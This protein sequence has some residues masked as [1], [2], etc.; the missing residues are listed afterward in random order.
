LSQQ[1]SQEEQDVVQVEQE[2]LQL[3]A[4]WQHVVG[5]QLSHLLL[6]NRFFIRLNQLS[7]S[8]QLE[9]VEPH[10]PYDPQLLHEPWE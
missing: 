9:Q 6:L 7:F 10:D 5:Q 3:G 8:Q 1:L 2:D 4:G